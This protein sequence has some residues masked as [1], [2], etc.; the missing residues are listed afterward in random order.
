MVLAFGGDD[1]DGGGRLVAAEGVTGVDPGGTADAELVA[2]A[3]GSVDDIGP[4]GEGGQQLILQ[5]RR[6]ADDETSASQ[7]AARR[8]RRLR[9]RPRLRRPGRYALFPSLLLPV[10][11]LSDPGWVVVV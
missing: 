11:E 1:G 3:I 7:P 10:A 2:E 9:F 5:W 8:A 4:G 6:D